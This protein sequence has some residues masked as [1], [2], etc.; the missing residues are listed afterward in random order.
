MKNPV[1]IYEMVFQF[2]GGSDTPTWLATHE[3]FPRDPYRQVRE[4]LAAVW[5]I[6]DLTDYNYSLSFTYFFPTHPLKPKLMLSFVAPCAI[7]VG[8]NDELVNDPSIE[9]FAEQW[10]FTFLDRE[11]LELPV[12][13]W[14]ASNP[15]TLYEYL[16][17]FDLGT[18]WARE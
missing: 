8:W 2:F 11:T 15:G 16:F 18:P 6:E 7:L 3:I 4:G 5:E 12:H 10:G 14:E 13:F 17:E 1:A 9:A